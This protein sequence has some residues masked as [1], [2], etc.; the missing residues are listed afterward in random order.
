M[1]LTLGAETGKRFDLRA[2]A[3]AISVEID[4]KHELE[5]R[6]Q[7]AEMLRQIAASVEHT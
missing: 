3:D 7:L 4:D 5:G 2:Y 6:R 1:V